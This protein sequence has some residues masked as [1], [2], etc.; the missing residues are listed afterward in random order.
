MHRPVSGEQEPPFKHAEVHET[1]S[2][3]SNGNVVDYLGRL[4]E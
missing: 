3:V 1:G 2:I 4:T